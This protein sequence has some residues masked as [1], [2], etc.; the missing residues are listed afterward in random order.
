MTATP[1]HLIAS[2]GALAMMAAVIGYGFYRALHL[3]LIRVDESDT[4]GADEGGVVR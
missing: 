4:A 2:I 1:L 3:R